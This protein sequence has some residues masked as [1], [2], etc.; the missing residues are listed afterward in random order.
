MKKFTRRHYNK[1]LL[2]LGMSAF[3]GVGLVS[4]G[5]AAWVMSKEADE[6]ASGNVTISTITDQSASI[7]LDS[8]IYTTSGDTKI[9]K[10][11]ISFNADAKDDE[12][13]LYYSAEQGDT[14]ENLSITVS[15]RLYTELDYELT[16]ELKLPKGILDAIQAGYIAWK[17][18]NYAFTTEVVPD[19]GSEAKQE[20]TTVVIESEPGSTDEKGTYRTFSFDIGFTWGEVFGGVNPS[21]YYDNAG[22]EIS[23]EEMQE[24]LQDFWSMI[25]G[26]SDASSA[27]T[28]GFTVVL[29]AAVKEGA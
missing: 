16:A 8:T 23:S 9:L 17:N 13:R 6:E 14:P 1:K 2:A 20:A 3:M 10:T 15:G 5:F 7:V 12:G 24:T 19:G 22:S 4:T 11:A 29:K 27:Q 26:K 25:T 28:L 21:M 18:G